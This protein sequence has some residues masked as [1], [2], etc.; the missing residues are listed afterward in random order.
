[1][2]YL[3]GLD[4]K[5]KLESVEYIMVDQP[6]TFATWNIDQARREEA[7]PETRFD[8]RW[9]AIKKQIIASN[10]DVLCLQELR[11]LET[12]KISVPCL[13][14]ELS[15]L[16]YDYRHAYY[17][18]DDVSFALA[19]FYKR[20]RFFV[21]DVLQWI[22]PGEIKPTL[23]RI[24]LG[25]RLRDLQNKHEFYVCNTHFGLGEAEKE[26]SVTYLVT[27]LAMLQRPYLCAGD[28]NFFDDRDGAKH[29]ALLLQDSVDLAHPLVNASGTFIGF[30]H[31]EFRQPFEKM[32]RLDHIAATRHKWET[33]EAAH[34]IGDMKQVQSRCYPSDHLMIALSLRL[35]SDK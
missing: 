15:L 9:P 30:A 25:L 31:D 24:V 2:G 6:F 16:G 14:Y 17:G 1:M 7:F 33:V 4:S 11:N 23:T 3:A 32:S 27:Q 20:E 35:P 10:V 28:Y 34:A 18:P 22:L 12:S 13:L 19:I 29:R 21:T 26:A 8:T 5:L